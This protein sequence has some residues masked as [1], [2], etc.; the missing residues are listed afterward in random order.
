MKFPLC[1][2]EVRAN[3]HNSKCHGCDKAPTN[4]DN[5][6]VS[7]WQKLPSTSKKLTNGG[8]PDAA[9]AYALQY[10]KKIKKRAGKCAMSPFWG[11]NISSGDSTTLRVAA[12]CCQQWT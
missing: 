4:K 11:A 7:G 9:G 1:L 12:T 3:F 6:T 5:C 2:T 10:T 8:A